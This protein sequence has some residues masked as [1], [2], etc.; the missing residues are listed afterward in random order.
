[1]NHIVSVAASL[2]SFGLICATY[3]C[4]IRAR[5]QSW[6]RSEMLAMILLSL[7]TG[8]FP[9]AVAASVVGLWEV[10]TED[11]SIESFLLGGTDLL[12][13]VLIVSTLVVIRAIV[14]ATY[15]TRTD[16]DNVLPLSPRPAAKTA[17][18]RK[19]A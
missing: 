9:L 19:A 16:P 14:R 12:A 7:F 17:I 1:M 18:R 15:P 4:N 13:V 6:F 2:A 5:R 8:L 11:G 3:Y 10:L